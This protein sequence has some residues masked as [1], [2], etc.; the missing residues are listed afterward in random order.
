MC[1]VTRAAKPVSELIRFVIG[2]DGAV[3]PDLAC[4]LPGRG[5]W[6][7]ASRTAVESAVARRLFARS[8]R[9]DVGMAVD[10]ARQVE[11]LMERRALDALSIARK[12]GQ[13]VVG[14]TRVEAAIAAG[15]VIGLVAAADAGPHGVRK[16]RAATRRRF[17]DGSLPLVGGFTAAQ[18]GL[19]LGRANVVHAALLAGPATEGFLARCRRLERFRGEDGGRRIGAVNRP[20]PGQ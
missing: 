17:G 12:A 4:R 20:E 19:A 3:V 18:L 8:F 1:I 11:E 5:V 10:L 16:L 7:T 9:R 14:F 13:V 6:V 2:P 15:P